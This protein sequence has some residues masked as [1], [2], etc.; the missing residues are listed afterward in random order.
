M[1]WL[2]CTSAS[3][4]GIPLPYSPHMDGGV[5]MLLVCCFLVTAYVLSRYR[6]YLGGQMADFL[7]NRD[8]SSLFATTDAEVRHK[9]VLGVQTCVLAGM[10]FFCHFCD[11]VPALPQHVH[12]F[13]LLWAYIGLCAAYLVVKWLCYVFLGWIFFDT[14]LVS[15]WLDSY[16]TLVYYSGFAL[17]PVVL[18]AVYF[19]LE[20]TVFAVFVLFL[21]LL[22]K[23]LMFYK[24]IKFFYNDL[25]GCI[26]LI[27]YFCALE[28]I[29]CLM[30][31][32]MMI[33]MND[34]LVLKF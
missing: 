7:L 2:S 23:M 31:Y 27:L 30:F 11:T 33:Q 14:N 1:M 32:R 25:Y 24:W 5:S 18:L 28:I 6:K 9:L 15:R 29:P 12:P 3:G 8:R 20:M 17:F 13:G 21:L 16:F 10:A 34:C 4:D 26:V 19:N 22:V